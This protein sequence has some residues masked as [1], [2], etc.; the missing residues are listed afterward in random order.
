MILH[1][2]TR[3]KA[4]INQRKVLVLIHTGRRRWC[5]GNL[6]GIL[7]EFAP[8]R[9]SQPNVPALKEFER[10]V[11]QHHCSTFRYG[12]QHVDLIVPGSQ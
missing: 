4:Q 10:T 8:F 5:A 9:H 3:H 11:P 1:H 12:L 7:T 2:F 6:V